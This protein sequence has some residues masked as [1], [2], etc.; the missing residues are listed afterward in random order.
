MAATVAMTAAEAASQYSAQQSQASA[1]KAANGMQTDAID[2][3]RINEYNQ[4][5]QRE[6]YYN[7]QAYQK[8][9][10]EAQQTRA[11]R[12]TA[13]ASAADSGVDPSSI[14]VRALAQEYAAKQ[15]QYD[16]DVG[17][18]RQ[19]TMQTIQTQEQGVDAQARSQINS[20]RQPVSPS[21]VS[22]ALQ[23]GGSA[24]SAYGRY[25][26]RAP[27]SDPTTG[28]DGGTSAWVDSMTPSDI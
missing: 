18:N 9:Y 7:D 1:Q 20:E 3:N 14:S 4:G 23:I 12:G 11:A 16:Q 10:A 15:G 21:W 8:M 19:A 22:P 13:L 6:I 5:S 17:Y 26:Y 2:Q 28:L 24:V 25:A 27:T